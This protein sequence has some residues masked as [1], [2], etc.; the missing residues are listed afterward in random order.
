MI[1]MM[2]YPDWFKDDILGALSRACVDAVLTVDVDDVK[3]LLPSLKEEQMFVSA[4]RGVMV[5]LDLRLLL[6]G[7]RL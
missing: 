4:C 3:T 6:P 2:V 1:A 5:E 7:Y